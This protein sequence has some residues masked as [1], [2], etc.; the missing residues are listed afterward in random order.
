MIYNKKNNLFF[1]ILVLFLIIY[2]PYITNGTI[3][4]DDWSTYELSLESNSYK[5]ILKSWFVGSHYTRPITSIY[6]PT[7]GFLFKQKI[8]LYIVN[9]LILFF[10][11]IYIFSF[12]CKKFF[13]ENFAIFFLIIS[14]CP[15]LSSANIFSPIEQS[16]GILSN[17]FVSISFLFMYFFLKNKKKKYLIFSYSFILIALLTYE[18]AIIFLPFLIFFRN[19]FDL[20]IN[21]KINYDNIRKILFIIL[22]IAFF[23]F[24][25]FFYQTIMMNTLKYLKLL[26]GHDVYKYGM[27]RDD[28]LEHLLKFSYKP[29]SLLFYEIPNLYFKTFLFIKK[30]I[31]SF[32]ESASI[33]LVVFLLIKKNLLDIK[34]KFKIL[35]IALIFFLSYSLL[36]FIHV[37]GASLPTITGYHNRAFVSFSVVYPF[38]LVY[39]FFLIYKKFSFFKKYILIIFLLI[40]YMHIFSFLIQRDNYI[41]IS[42]EQKNILSNLNNNFYNKKVIIFAS[43]PTYLENNFNDE[44]IFSQEVNDWPRAIWQYSKKNIQSERIFYDENCKNILKFENS[45]FS[46]LRPSRSRRINEK[47]E[48]EFFSKY[49]RTV[50]ILDYQEF[51][52][53]KYESKNKYQIFQFNEN[54]INQIL[55]K[56][57]GCKIS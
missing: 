37:M 24:I 54:N 14:I 44:T 38:C 18:T 8:Y 11:T 46:G 51:F 57:F 17:F 29:F 12:I 20:N 56:A 10:I 26:S 1:I 45:K 15:T 39:F 25:I 48:E 22:I 34:S 27:K 23:G 32:L 7:I 6:L 4:Y 19:K 33:T 49:P 5:E 3:I 31:S 53:Y 43:I 52:I 2:I 16:Q 40:T 21:N 47:V 50:S 42:K 35:D 9:N 13:T 28:F 30:N 36:I 41:Q 55:A